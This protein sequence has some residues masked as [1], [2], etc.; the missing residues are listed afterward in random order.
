MITCSAKPGEFAMA[1]HEK[2]ASFFE[3]DASLP[4]KRQAAIVPVIVAWLL[5][6]IVG[7]LI[8]H[9]WRLIGD[10]TVQ[11]GTANVP[12]AN[13]SREGI[14][15]YYAVPFASPP[16]LEVPDGLNYCIVTE[17]S[18]QK[19]KLKSAGNLLPVKVRWKADG[20]PG[21]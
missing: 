11:E 3:K 14:E 1:D 9:P 6:I 10:S 8:P 7:F 21:R 17:Q 20:Q 12:G 2:D 13:D 18:A 19:F 16:K 4:P 5:D 15:V